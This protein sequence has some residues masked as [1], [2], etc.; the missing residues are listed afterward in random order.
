MRKKKIS[1]VRLGS[2]ALRKSSGAAIEVHWQDRP[3]GADSEP[4][5]SSSQA[6][7]GSQYS[8]QN[9]NNQSIRLKL[10]PSPLLHSKVCMSDRAAD[11][12]AGPGCPDSARDAAEYLFLEYL[13][14]FFLQT[15]G[16]VEGR[17]HATC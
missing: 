11:G 15:K 9:L 7:A 13:T 10:K 17:K 1:A 12:S 6:A 3:A 16:L 4:C 8:K 14:H 5:E 2:G